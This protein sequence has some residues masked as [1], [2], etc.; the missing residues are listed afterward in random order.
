MC[1]RKCKALVSVV[2]RSATLAQR[3][4]F[5]SQIHETLHLHAK[6]EASGT[7]FILV[8]IFYFLQ[9]LR[10]LL[11]KTSER[12]NTI[13]N[14][15]QRNPVKSIRNPIMPDSDFKKTDRNQLSGYFRISASEFILWFPWKTKLR[16]LYPLHFSRIRIVV[17]GYVYCIRHWLPLWPIPRNVHSVDISRDDRCL[18]SDTTWRMRSWNFCFYKF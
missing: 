10:K 6:S 14:L 1:L 9:L 11:L 5:V 4:N 7:N 3:Q 16:H 18:H 12:V 2:I 17:I 13:Q 8:E 15:S